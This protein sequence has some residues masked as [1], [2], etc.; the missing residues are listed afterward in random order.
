MIRSNLALDLL[1]E[2]LPEMSILM[3]LQPE[4]SGINNESLHKNWKIEQ[5]ISSEKEGHLAA[6]VTF[7]V[8]TNLTSINGTIQM[9]TSFNGLIRFEKQTMKK[10]PREMEKSSKEYLIQRLMRIIFNARNAAIHS[11]TKRISTST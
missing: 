10:I 1:M 3:E 11:S 4:M 6:S 9:P 8:R 2:Q 7:L 5:K